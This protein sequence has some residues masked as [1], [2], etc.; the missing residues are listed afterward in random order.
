MV[1]LCLGTVA[2]AEPVREILPFSI[3]GVRLGD[4]LR[5]VTARFPQLRT[6]SLRTRDGVL[7]GV[8]AHT[9]QGYSDGGFFSV[10]FQPEDMGGGAW[11]VTLN[12]RR[13]S[14]DE[15]LEN[16]LARHVEQYG[17]YDLLCR[18]SYAGH[19]VY[20][21]YWGSAPADCSA[22]G[23][24]PA[25]AHLYLNLVLGSWTEEFL[26]LSAPMFGGGVTPE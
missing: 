11:N 19:A 13:R 12:T 8:R 7:L 6:S 25:T 3:H 14:P 21:I 9:Q 2:R 17:P 16:V 4:R 22:P 10:L 20:H 24:R 15:R 26:V 23:M 18:V 1:L 5:D